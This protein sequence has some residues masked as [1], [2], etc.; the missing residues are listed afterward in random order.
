[1]TKPEKDR[2]ASLAMLVLVLAG[3]LL[4][5]QGLDWDVGLFFHP[6]ERNIATAA[7]RLAWPDHL[8]P[9]FHAYNGLSLYLP[10]MLAELVAI[11]GGRPGNDAAAIALASR[12]I[13]AAFSTATLPFLWLCARDATDARWAL[14]ALACAVF[15]PGLIQA[16][17]F[18][19][20]ESGLVL[21]LVLLLFL[22][23]RHVAGRLTLGRFALLTGLA[24]GFGLGLKNSALAFGLVPAVAVFQ[25]HGLRRGLL[26]ALKAG[27]IAGPIALAMALLSTP[28][29]WVAPGDYWSTMR[30]ESG[31]VS[32]AADVFWTWQF[33]HA[34]SVLFE[35]GQ[36]PWI[37]GPLVAPLGLA[38]FLLALIGAWRER[39]ASRLLLGA[40]LFTLAYGAIVMSWHAKFVRYLLPLLPCFFL[41]A[42][43]LLRELAVGARRK[44][45][46]IATLAASVVAGTAQALIYQRP[47]PRL[48]AWKWLAPQLK[49]EDRLAVEPVDLTPPYAILPT[50]AVRIDILPLTDPPSEEKLDRIASTLA[51]SRWLLIVS[52]RHLG[53]LPQLRD[54][55]PFMCNYYDALLSGRFGYERVATF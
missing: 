22:G 29:L 43:A 46:V 5:F 32:G 36:L 7:A 35:I 16:A 25:T 39:P 17:H 30:F 51:G 52:R 13:S 1:M 50:P 24:L 23:M 27:M 48:E 26:P 40:A 49:A 54:R 10:R 44:L 41:F 45:L 3:A 47:D 18:G 33:T 8:V 2:N 42:T 19:T 6:D 21:C 28:Q 53:V 11:A 15:C 20:T 34:T 38:G 31:V 9:D 37:A 4:R 14:V 12:W 55:F